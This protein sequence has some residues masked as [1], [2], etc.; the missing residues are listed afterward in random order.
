MKIF[1]TGATE[2]I[3]RILCNE[4]AKEYNIIAL[5]RR[6]EKASVLFKRPVDILKWNP[7]GMDGWERSLDGSEVLVNLAGTNFNLRQM[8]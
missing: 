5:T 2:F 3:G 7:D 1:V 6:P 8:D 4:L